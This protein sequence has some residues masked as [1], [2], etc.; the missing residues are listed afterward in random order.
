MT[1]GMV[2]MGNITNIINEQSTNQKAV[3][4]YFSKLMKLVDF[5]SK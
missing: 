3:K 5:E 4:S 2:N 1:T